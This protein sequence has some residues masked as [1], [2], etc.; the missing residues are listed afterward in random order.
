M[1]S[2]V[3]PATGPWRARNRFRLFVQGNHFFP[4]MLAAI[5]AARERIALEMYWIETGA[6]AERFIGGLIE[7]ADRGVE[8]FVLIDD[9]GSLELSY[10]DR[11]R[12]TAAGIALARHNPLRFR[13]GW[14]NLARDHRKILLID[15]R[16]AFVGGTGISDEFDGADGWRENMLRVEGDCVADWWALFTRNWQRWSDRACRP[17]RPLPIGDTPGRVVAG[18]GHVGRRPIEGTALADISRAS[19]RVWLVTPYFM[20]PARLRQALVRARRRG[21]DVRLLLPSAETCD[22]P[23]FQGAGERWYEWLLG[24]G[25]RIFEYR[26]RMTHQKILLA[27]ERVTLGSSNFDRWSLRWN[28]EANQVLHSP[29]FAAEVAEL[30]DRDFAAAPELRLEDWRQ[31]SVFARVREH[32]WGRFEAMAASIAWRHRAVAHAVRQQAGGQ[33]GKADG[34][35]R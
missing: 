1:A 12:L 6:V 22:I 26:A 9:F 30:L 18:P 24:H 10:R 34:D 25:I 21:A 8:V 31:R 32:F 11:Q 17:S 20:P 13:V 15:D 29:G 28:L 2:A 4:A 7:A 19:Q 27:D 35:R 33:S 5:D 3:P 23:L 14:G 16:W